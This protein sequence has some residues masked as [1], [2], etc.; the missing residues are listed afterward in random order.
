[1]SLLSDVV[2]SVH[3]TDTSLLPIG[4][5][6]FRGPGQPVIVGACKAATRKLTKTNIYQSICSP[7]L[8]WNG[9]EFWRIYTK[10]DIR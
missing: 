9:Q 2:G 5:V 3:V 10:R 4:R 6:A 8:Q 7:F 1:M